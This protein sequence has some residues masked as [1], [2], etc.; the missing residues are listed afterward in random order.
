MSGPEI[1]RIH[2]LFVLP[3]QGAHSATV[4]FTMEYLEGRTL[5]DAIRARGPLPWKEVLPIAL[6]ICE[7]LRLIHRQGIV[8]RDLKSANIMLCDRQGESCAVLMDFG[9]ATLLKSSGDGGDTG[10]VTGTPR[11]HGAGTV[12]LG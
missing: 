10:T 2:D 7:G 8:H 6:S 3:A 5:L 11:L 4:F 1:C 12:H 9:L